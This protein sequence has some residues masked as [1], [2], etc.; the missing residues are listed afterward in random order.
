MV[1]MKSMEELKELIHEYLQTQ[2]HVVSSKRIA[3]RTSIKPK[4][5]RYLLRTYF[6]N[7]LVN[8]KYY[9]H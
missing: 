5:C 3:I 6:E 9:K 7:N 8:S 2:S 1:T 4:V